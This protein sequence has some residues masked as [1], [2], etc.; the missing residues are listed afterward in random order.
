MKICFAGFGKGYIEVE[1]MRR[2]FHNII[3][4]VIF[5]GF[6]ELFRHI[7]RICNYYEGYKK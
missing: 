4:D 1:V 5:W 6:Y 3:I 7:V 2:N